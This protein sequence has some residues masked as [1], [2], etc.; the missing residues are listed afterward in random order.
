M[1]RPDTLGTEQQHTSLFLC[2]HGTLPRRCLEAV[3]QHVDRASWPWRVQTSSLLEGPPGRPFFPKGDD[4]GL[5]GKFVRF[6]TR[7]RWEPSS[8]IRAWTPLR[9]S[10]T[11]WRPPR[12]RT[13]PRGR[14]ETR[15]STW[16]AQ[17]HRTWRNP[18]G[19]LLS[20]LPRFP[21]VFPF[22]IRHDPLRLVEPP[23]VPWGP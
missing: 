23:L 22:R 18:R 19:T 4:F 5:K 12:G 3:L 11:P 10:E 8:F 16:T 9:P 13:H 1:R 20:D 2:P 21:L 17:A 14:N 6:R 7:T 15:P